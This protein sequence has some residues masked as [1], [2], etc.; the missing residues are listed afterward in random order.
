MNERNFLSTS[1]I[2]DLNPNSSFIKF[3]T[4]SKLL[5]MYIVELSCQLSSVTCY[6]LENAWPTLDN[7]E[8]FGKFV[9]AAD[10]AGM[11]TTRQVSLCA[12]ADT[13]EYNGRRP[14]CRGA[15]LP[16]S[17]V[18]VSRKKKPDPTSPIQ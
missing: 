16:S 3:V 5:N 15:R 1:D 14:C 7:Q 10:V 8:A 2:L 9:P 11:L 4:K 13:I 12:R 18:V 17:A 6:V